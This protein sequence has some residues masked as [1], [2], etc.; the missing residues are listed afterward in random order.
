M[1]LTSMAPSMVAEAIRDLREKAE[2]TRQRTY[3]YRN[4]FFLGGDRT[5]QYL[6]RH[7]GEGPTAWAERKE[8]FADTG[9]TWRAGQALVSALYGHGV[10]RELLDTGDRETA[11]FQSILDASKINSKQRMV[12]QN[13][14]VSGDGFALVA[15]SDSLNSLR[16]HSVDPGNI[17]VEVHPDDAMREQTV[18]ERRAN[19]NR[20]DSFIYWV[21]TDE[22][23]TLVDEDGKE[24]DQGDGVFGWQPNPYGVIPY[25]HWR[26]MPISESYWGHSPVAA[27]MELH[28]YANNI[29]SQVDRLALY[30]AHSILAIS[31]H[32]IEST[33]TAGETN[34]LRL[35]AE[36]SAQYLAPSAA[37]GDV[38]A[39]Y[40]RSRREA[41]EISG[42]PWSIV[43]GGQAP[44]GY[45]LTVEYRSMAE[46]V[47]DLA[48]EA[49][50]AELEMLRKL[51]IIGKVHGLPLP[52]DPDVQVDLNLEITPEDKDG[53][54]LRDLD[55][56]QA[57]L[58]TKRDYLLRHRPDIPPDQ[59][60]AY[61]EQLAAERPAAPAQF[62]G[63][64]AAEGFV[65]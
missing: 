32:N 28:R 17:F 39:V 12:A 44:S 62:G 49:K 10:K 52:E 41:F 18:I 64:A 34:A 1:I 43:E 46:V 45:A 31:D 24:L 54:R 9:L 42:I 2:E 53:L 50:D 61:I 7:P 37:I 26:G 55:D 6:T 16:I 56:L 11:A 21:W 59:I 8:R 63:A 23:K 14:V 30:Q 19:P 27:C 25:V 13:Q 58:M 20:V 40:Q 47:E 5:K 65:L 35:S 15:W 36:G 29:R 33:I 4:D 3:D 22:A 60:D 38:E 51:C 48:V 57:G